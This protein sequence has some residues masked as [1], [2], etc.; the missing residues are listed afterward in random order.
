ML[1]YFPGQFI[2]LLI[3]EYHREIKKAHRLLFF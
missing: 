3:C 1:S 2:H